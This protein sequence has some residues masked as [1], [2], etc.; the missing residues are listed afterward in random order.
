MKKLLMIFTCLLFAFIANSQTETKS[1]GNGK[2]QI[3]FIDVGQGDCELLISPQGEVVLFDNGVNKFCE[4]PLNYLKKIGI[5]EINYHITSHYHDDHIGC[6][7]E[8]FSKF[9]LSKNAVVYDRGF[10]SN[11]AFYK[12]YLSAIG[13]HRKTAIVGDSIVLDKSSEAPVRIVFIASNGAGIKTINENDLSIVTVVHFG[14]FDAELGGDLSGYTAD[15]YQDIETTIAD[16]VGQ[17]EVYKVHHHG[18]RY[19]SNDYWLSKI[20]PK[21]GIISASSKIGRNH[22]HPTE[23]CLDRLHNVNIKTY[24]TEIGGGA[25]PDPLLDVIAGSI[26]IQAEPNGKTFTVS[27]DNKTDT[28]LDWGITEQQ[29]TNTA[30]EDYLFFWSKN[31]NIYHYKGCSQISSIK[32]ENL[33]KGNIPPSGKVL[34]KGCPKKHFTLF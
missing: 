13:E 28:Y 34:H 30:T 2:L 3:H 6:A 11:L 24:W 1:V 26:L 14:K 9:P 15:S 33:V 21:V 17:V 32:S 23:E 25:Q 4:F 12:R 5:K 29:Y 7:E 20:N 19:S 22:Q 18:S 8:V 10:S 27:Y 31:S 16:K